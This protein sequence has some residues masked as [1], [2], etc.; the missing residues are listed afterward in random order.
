M[1]EH[2]VRQV[3][4]PQVRQQVAVTKLSLKADLISIKKRTQQLR[5]L[6]QEVP[7][8]LERGSLQLINAVSDE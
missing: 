1:L 4:T 6:I 5:E 2:L 7:R 8:P 3:A